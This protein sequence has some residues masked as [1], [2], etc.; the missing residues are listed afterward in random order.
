MPGARAVP[1][2]RQTEY[3]SALAVRRGCA[4]KLGMAQLQLLQLQMIY[5]LLCPSQ[6]DDLLIL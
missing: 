2:A 1:V 3:K 6:S 4:G 5:C